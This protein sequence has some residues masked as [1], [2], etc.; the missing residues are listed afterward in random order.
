LPAKP[1]T[2]VIR[3]L[4][5]NEFTLEGVAAAL[6]G[7]PR[8]KVFLQADEG[9]EILCGYDAYRSSGAKKDRGAS[10]A[11]FDSRPR[12]VDRVENAD[13]PVHVWSWRAGMLLGIQKDVLREKVAGFQQ[14]GMLQR[15]L[16]AMIERCDDGVDRYPDFDA[17]NDYNA[18]ISNL[19]NYNPPQELTVR[20]SNEAHEYGERVDK[21]A[22]AITD[23]PT[24]V[25]AFR[26][27]SDKLR[28]SFARLLL[29][30]HMCERAPYW[31][32][33]DIRYGADGAELVSGRVAKQAY[34][35]MVKFLLP[36]SV[37]VYE[38]F[39]KPGAGHECQDA[40]WTTSYILVHGLETFNDSEFHRQAPRSWRNDKKRR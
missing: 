13:D 2:P 40:R 37:A 4:I 14:D 8:G 20:L 24:T 29:T 15:F 33:I 12:R 9:V 19:A 31:D 39:F 35:L 21:L 22:R 10:L 38:D 25:P 26:G 17:V 30:L 1:E 11:L 34:L 7:N 5:S 16:M 28:G 32:G 18:L 6:A 36:H 27:H 3:C 23:H